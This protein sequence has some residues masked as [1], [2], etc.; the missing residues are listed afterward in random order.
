MWWTKMI[1]DEL[2]KWDVHGAYIV[3]DLLEDTSAVSLANLTRVKA[4]VGL[5]E[6][7]WADEPTLQNW[8]IGSAEKLPLIYNLSGP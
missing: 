5:H 6:Y 1:W 2:T 8:V 7:W 3:L 4:T